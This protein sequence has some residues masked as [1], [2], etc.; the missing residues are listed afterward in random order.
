V[1]AARA[2]PEAVVLADRVA[3]QAGETLMDIARAHDVG[4]VEMRAA[5]PGLDP[6]L[7]PPGAVVLLPTAHL[8]PPQLEQAPLVIN[9]A[10]MRLYWRPPEGT[11]VSF[12]VGIGRDGMDLKPTMTRVAGKRRDPTWVP[13]PSV[14]AEKPWLPARVPPGP[15]NPLGAFS[16]DLALGLVRIH[17]TNLPD[18]VGRRVS[19]GCFR[20]Y[21][22]DI[23]RLFPQVAVGTPVAIID[24]P[25]AIARA[26][27][28][29]W[30][31]IHPGLDAA[32]AIEAGKPGSPQ[33][34]QDLESAIARTVGD[35]L[36]RIDWGAVAWSRSHPLGIPVRISRPQA[37]PP[38]PLAETKNDPP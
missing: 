17:G 14:L 10:A 36:W 7:P 1:A 9:L 16:L 22:E 4:F 2:E 23:E 29:W 15:D 28:E 19:H 30:L 33:Q 37:P 34:G 21:P 20:L 26:D 12:P 18:G 38:Q 3:V 5:N 24:M 11:A 25:I 31:E 8:P 32:D 13:P 27:G 6:W 35:D